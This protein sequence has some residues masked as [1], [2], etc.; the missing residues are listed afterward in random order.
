MSTYRPHASCLLQTNCAKIY[1]QFR[2]AFNKSQD[3]FRRA[4]LFLYL[5]R[6]GY[7]GLCRYNLRGEFNVPFGSYKKPYFRK[8]SCI[9]SLKKR[10]M[11]FSIVSLTR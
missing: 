10:R 5:N 1:Y 9:A 2:E 8:Q 11:P 6:Y 7:D 3:P 4:V